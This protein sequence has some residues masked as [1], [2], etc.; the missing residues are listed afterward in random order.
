MIIKPRIRGFICTTAHPTGCAKNVQDQV[1]YVRGQPAVAGSSNA[2]VVGCSAGYGLASRISAAFGCGANTIGVSFEREPTQRKTGSAG[3]YN[4]VAF[5]R[6]ANSANLFS[7]TI[8]KDAFAD[9]TKALVIDTIRSNLPS[10]DL[11]VY[12]LAAP[13]RT[14]PKTGE[15]F[16]SAIKPIG[17]TMN[18]RTLKLD[19]LTGNCEVAE[20][21]IEAALDE[22]ISATTAVMGGE[23]WEFWIEALHDAGVLAENFKT[24]AYTYIGNELTRPIYRGGTIGKAKEHL[25][26]TCQNLNQRFG[27]SGFEASV[28]VLK[29]VVTQASTAIP[30]VPLYF[31]ILFREMKA[32]GTHEDCIDHIYRLFHE[33]LYQE[34]R[35]VDEAKRIRMDD[36]ELDEAVQ[37][38]VANSWERINSAN[39]HEL[40]DVNGFQAEFLKLFGFG[41]PDIDYDAEVDPVPATG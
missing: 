20:I 25:D 41:H 32:Q 4:N 11:L 33:Q 5:D 3:W 26:Q 8:D 24:L 21:D 40:A 14:H 12:S 16:R 28:A 17:K 13:I 6:L 30:V 35:R 31:S 39:V 23:D 1:N 18:S 27:Q 15:V 34:P 38:R 9:Q 10:I 7:H 19:V 22:E 29:A 2:L 36:Y 37:S